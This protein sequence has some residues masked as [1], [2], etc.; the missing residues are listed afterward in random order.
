MTGSGIR[1]I[2]VRCSVDRGT[3]RSAVLLSGTLAEPSAGLAIA[4]LSG[5]ADEAR[6]AVQAWFPPRLASEVA[7]LADRPLLAFA[8]GALSAFTPPAA[9]PAKSEDRE[10]KDA[11]LA[12]LDLDALAF[13]LASALGC[14]PGL[15]F[16]MPWGRF[17]SALR[18]LPSHRRRMILDAATST[19]IG[20]FADEA[21]WRDF[22]REPG[23]KATV[24][25][26][27]AAAM[28]RMND[29]IRRGFASQR[30]HSDSRYWLYDDGLDGPIW[31]PAEAV[32]LMA[33]V[34]S[35][36]AEA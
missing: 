34:R 18:W 33:E 15:V 19:R 4:L 21:A 29:H 28:E 6:A 35:P 11:R 25:E 20:H 5:D 17:L 8:L 31:T 7:P 36:R 26:T 3:G 24:S 23:A 14:E 2:D 12:D 1:A 32:A 22:T 30:E 9:P 13:E 16:E 27:E 10:S